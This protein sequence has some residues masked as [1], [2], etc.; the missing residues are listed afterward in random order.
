MSA[1]RGL[2]SPEQ[3]VEAARLALIVRES[4]GSVLLFALYRAVLERESAARAV[5]EQVSLPVTEFALSAERR[6]PLERL[7]ELSEGPRQLVFV[8][9]LEDAFPEALG[10]LNLQRDVLREVPHPLVFWV[11]E[12]GLQEIARKA[13]D[14]WSLRTAILDFRTA[15]MPEAA[16]AAAWALSEPLHY[17]TRSD[18]ERQVSLYQRLL[19]EYEQAQRKDTRYASALYG[20]LGLAHFHLGNWRQAEAALRSAGEAAR[21][22]GDRS[23]LAGSLHNLGMVAQ[24][25]GK[26]EEA[27]RLYR[28]SLEIKREVGDRQGEAYSLGQLGILAHIRGDLETADA[29]YTAVLRVAREMGD[30]SSQAKSL[31]NLGMVA[32]DR[33]NLDEA[34]RL[35]RDSLEIKRQVG[36]RPAEAQTLHQLGMVAEIRGSLDEAEKLYH[37]SLDTEREVGNR[38]GIAQSLHQLGN[39]AY[40]RGRLDE[41]ER[42]YRESFQIKREVGDRPGEA[43]TLHQLGMVEEERGNL[44]GALELMEE[45]LAMLEEIGSPDREIA[46]ES[47]QR[48]RRELQQATDASLRSE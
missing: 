48:V 45:A 37:Q 44:K 23:S 2:L 9:D 21:D 47:A 28:E 36:D 7:R 3:Q 17:A 39:V 29:R 31:H 32:Q 14:F 4:D 12:H 26:L 34:E 33:G 1:P 16:A 20:R 38:P 15:A 30:R 5:R 10:Y 18:L 25:R 6:N 35:Y 22:A 46:R 41:A 8:Y 42:L 40:L 13:P 11:R 43:S 27:E 24:L 19:Q